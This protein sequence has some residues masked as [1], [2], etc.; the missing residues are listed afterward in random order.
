[1]Y[2]GNPHL[3]NDEQIDELQEIAKQS[4]IEFSP[5]RSELNLRKVIEQASSGFLEGLTTIPV[6]DKPRTTYESIAHSLGHLVG[7]APGIL[8]GPLKFGAT[9][10]A[11]LGAKGAS[12]IA[13]RGATIAS[14]NISV[15]MLFGDWVKKG[16]SKGLRKTKLETLDFMKRGAKTR[17]IGGQALHLGSAMAMSNIWGGT[18]EIMNGLI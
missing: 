8:A 1:M 7:F 10:L 14:K 2:R 6:G 5:I 13:E 15:P 11:K 9:G 18:D 16:A 12:E 3:F 17:D 4:G